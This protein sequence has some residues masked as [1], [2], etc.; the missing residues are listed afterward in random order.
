M[1]QRW[2]RGTLLGLTVILTS[3]LFYLLVTRMDSVP[4][5]SVADSGSSER[6]DAGIDQFKFTRSRG[7]AVQWEVQAARARVFEAEN[8]ARL[9]EVR[10]TLFGA[11]GWELKLE[12]D[13]G[14]V[15]TVS[16][17]FVLV[18]HAAPIVVQL[19]SG[20]TIK[21]NH[22]AWKDE[23]RTIR[24]DDPITI[25][26]NGLEVKGRGFV[27]KLDTEEFN[28]LGDVHVAIAQ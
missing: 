6:S 20:Y 24:T 14:T 10:V 17:D 8:R 9:E 23:D 19:E 13:E 1:W 11:K 22:L 21:T 16:K 7:G 15:D 26:G 2:A 27:G 3:F 12:G 4:P 28:I 5:P 25:Y 18:K